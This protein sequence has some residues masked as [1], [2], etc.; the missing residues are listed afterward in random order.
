MA[1]SPWASAAHV[2][3]E[4]GS[5]EE[6]EAL[7]A[8]E[9]PLRPQRILQRRAVLRFPLP[10][11]APAA[12]HALGRIRAVEVVLAEVIKTRCQAVFSNTTQPPYILLKMSTSDLQH[13]AEGVHP[14]PR[15]APAQRGREPAGGGFEPGEVEPVRAGEGVQEATAG[16]HCY[17]VGRVRAVSQHPRRGVHQLLV[18][19]HPHLSAGVR[20]SWDYLAAQNLSEVQM[21]TFTK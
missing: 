12:V 14:Q 18:A 5:R 9:D 11:P 10:L 6:E 8:R 16:V 20:S 7:L 13:G 1:V 19:A 4:V 2:G 3:G 17:G 15:H 21:E